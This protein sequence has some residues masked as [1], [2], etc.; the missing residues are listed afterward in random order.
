MT[1]P[2]FFDFEQD[3]VIS[4]RCI[5]M[6]VRLKLDTCGVKLKLAHWHQFTPSERQSLVDL[7]CEDVATT[8][9]YREHLQS[10]VVGHTGQPAKSLDIDPQPPWQSTTVPPQVQTQAQTHQI[11]VTD[12]QW[13]SLS[14]AQRFALIKLSRPSHENRNFVPAMAE[15]GLV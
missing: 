4:L 14:H 2:A 6:T 1:A 11:S 7:P 3:F 8:V 9:A 10:L 5:P 13:Q 15:F 12:D